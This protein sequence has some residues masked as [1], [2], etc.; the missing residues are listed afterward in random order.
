MYKASWPPFEGYTSAHSSIILVN[1][2]SSSMAPVYPMFVCVSL[3]VCTLDVGS[4]RNLYSTQ[5]LYEAV[6][7]LRDPDYSIN[8]FPFLSP[9]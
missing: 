8:R 7:A 1:F 6:A 5:D 4:I 9:F 2:I 3:C